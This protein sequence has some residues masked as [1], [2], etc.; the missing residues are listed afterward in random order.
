MLK[1]IVNCSR[2]A[3]VVLC[4]YMLFERFAA[5]VLIYIENNIKLNN[6]ARCE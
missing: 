6:V 1:C 2:I 4:L 5:K 3:I